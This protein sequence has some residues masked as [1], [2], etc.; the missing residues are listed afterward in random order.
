MQP[1]N[2]RQS[3]VIPQMCSRGAAAGTNHHIDPAEE[4]GRE[5]GR[6]GGVCTCALSMGRP[7]R[8]QVA[9]RLCPEGAPARGA[10]HDVRAA[11]ATCAQALEEG[12]DRCGVR[13]DEVAVLRDEKSVPGRGSDEE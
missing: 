4:G 3:A 5:G 11:V 7:R 8:A 10:L 12:R 2:R 1:Q 6:K 13:D 9:N